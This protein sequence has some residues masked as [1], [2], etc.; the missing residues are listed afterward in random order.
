M[1]IV[2]AYVLALSVL[3]WS[4]SKDKTKTRQGLK[5]A[6]KAFENI[7]PAFAVVLL[8]IGILLTI[9]SPATVTTMM[10]KDS[11]FYGM[12]IAGIIG[13]ITLI[14]GFIAFPLVKAV[15]DMGAGIQQVAI[16]VSTLMMVGVVTAPL[17]RQFF[18][19]KVMLLRNCMSFIFAF[20]VAYVLGQVMSL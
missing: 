15:L 12:L 13:S 4:Y 20:V 10:G 2:I 9:I 3:V 18:N 1:D 19:T 16:F 7:L 17:E 6:W 5:K 8:L 11:G 14:P